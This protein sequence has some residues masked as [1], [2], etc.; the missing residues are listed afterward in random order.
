MMDRR[1]RRSLALVI[2][3]LCGDA[4]GQ[5]IIGDGGD[6][7]A[8][9]AAAAD[10]T[11]I[12]IQSNEVFDATLH[13]AGK[14]L[15]IRAGAGFTPT[16]RGREGLASVELLPASSSVAAVFEGLTLV[17]GEDLLL[18]PCPPCIPYSP[19]AVYVGGTGST[20]SSGAVVFRGCTI[21]GDL[22]SIGTGSSTSVSID[23]VQT[24]VE[25]DLR[26]GGTGEYAQSCIVRDSTVNGQVRVSSIGDAFVHLDARR[27]R[28][29]GRVQVGGD[30]TFVLLE[31][32]LVVPGELTE[33]VGISATSDAVARFVNCTVTGFEFG[34]GGNPTPTWE[35]M[36][37]YGNTDSVRSGVSSSQIASSWI[38][39]GTHAGLNGNFTAEPLVDSDHAYFS[40]AAGIDAGNSF[41]ADLGSLDLLGAPRIQDVDGDGTAAVNVGAVEGGSLAEQLQPMPCEVSLSAGGDQ[42]LRL[43]AGPSGALAIYRILGSASGTTPSIDLGD[44]LFLPLAVD[45]YFGLTVSSPLAGAFGNFPGILNAQGEASAFL[46]VPAGADPSLAGLVLHHAFVTA[47][48][49]GV[50]TSTSNPA[51]VTLVP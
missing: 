45:A 24:V 35:N 47:T 21:L 8:A 18:S 23:V 44:G 4:S 30:N 41:A 10:G 49:Q 38:G 25:G 40:C 13:W 28:V 6:L 50:L 34:V 20:P 16:L 12:E 26:F 2:V 51:P 36:L 1:E 29:H 15:T 46:S 11:V 33:G 14:T 27:L 19:P 43:R 32:S 3:C 39:D 17:A 31:S 48:P 42:D 37:I 7:E 22:R 5:V 9:T